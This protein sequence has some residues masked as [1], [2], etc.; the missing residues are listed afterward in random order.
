[1]TGAGGGYDCIDVRGAI[2]AQQCVAGAHRVVQRASVAQPEMRRAAAGDGGRREVGHGVGRR[3]FAVIGD[4]RRLIV[5][6]TEIQAAATE[7]RGVEGEHSGPER[8]AGGFA[9][10]A[11][12][13]DGGG[14]G[15]ALASQG[16]R[17]AHGVF[18]DLFG[19]RP[20]LGLVCVQDRWIGPAGQHGREHPR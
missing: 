6:R 12:V 16:E 9:L 17:G 1:M 10:G 18:R 15:G 11:G 19:D 2:E 8:G 5:E 14:D 20:A 13:F 3:G 7:L 4:D